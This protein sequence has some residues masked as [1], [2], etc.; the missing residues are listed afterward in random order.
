VDADI[1][2]TRWQFSPAA[3]ASGK[4]SLAFGTLCAEA[5]WR[6]LE[7]VAPYTRRLFS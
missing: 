5:Q 4:P 1:G 3:A 6:Y 2:A 7:S